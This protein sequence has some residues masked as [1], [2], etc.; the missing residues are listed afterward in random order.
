MSTTAA[1]LAHPDV[2]KETHAFLW[3]LVALF[4]VVGAW[5]YISPLDVV[6]N[7]VGEVIPSSQVKSIQHLEGGIVREIMVREGDTVE[8]GQPLVALEGTAT[9]ADVQE[10]RVRILALKADVARL[11]AERTGAETIAFPSE[12]RD[13]EDLTRLA[14][15]RFEARRTRLSGEKAGLAE[16]IQQRRQDI[17]EITARLKNT[18]ESLKLQEEQI[19]IS[20]EL[21]KDDLT[22]RMLHLDLLKEANGLRSRIQEDTAALGRAGAALKEAEQKLR[23]LD[24]SFREEVQTELDE[25]RRSLEEFIERMRKFQDSLQRTVLRSPVNGVVKTLYVYTVGGVVRPGGTVADVVPRED[26]LVVE[27]KLA[28]Q[29]VGYVHPGQEVR[30][31]LASSD[32]VRF[33]VLEGKVVNVS[34]D[35]VVGEDQ[36]PY[37]KV[38]IET[39]F[40]RF[41][42]GG[43]VYQLVPGVQVTCAILTGSRTVLEYV[44]D[45]FLRGFSSA[46]RE[47]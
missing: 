25:H 47:R 29:D 19:R 45:P 32:A 3:I 12:L 21:L 28:V 41:A 15:Q 14:R 44:L 20:E 40:D 16:A 24:D 36:V 34:P 22:N 11:E 39:E 9:G 27:A 43:L 18:R 6:S 42:K 31:K 1:R 46:M 4:L 7:A 17:K 33:G 5:A 38:R 23:T 2:A 30:V 26:R 10:L 8:E 13:H 37:Y 35:T